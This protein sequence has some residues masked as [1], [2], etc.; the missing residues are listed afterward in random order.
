MMTYR[1]KLRGLYAITPDTPDADDCLARVR[2]ALR[3]GARILQYRDKS[4]DA[5][6]QRALALALRALTRDF[7]ALLIVNDN[8]PLALAVDADGVHLGEGDGDLAAAR[9]AL[10]R[11]KILGASCCADFERARAAARAGADYVAFGAVF[12]SPTKPRAG[13]ANLALF[14]RCR[15][16]LD[17]SVCAIGGITLDNAAPVIAA[18]ADMLA[19]IS[20]IFQTDAPDA[21]E[22]KVRAYQSLFRGESA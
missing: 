19:V 21:I 7:E 18:G 11:G 5:A 9:A 17:V 2:A 16:E 3:G 10:G 13:R 4:R 15:G 22:T 1:Y 8:L 6:R 14:G 12:A 20:G